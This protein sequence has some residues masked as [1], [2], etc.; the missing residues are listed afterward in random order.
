M[1]PVTLALLVAGFLLLY[2][3]VKNR[4][5]LDVVKNALA[6]KPI[7]EARALK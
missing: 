2:G 1:N 5:P 7:G 4:N 6:G 3:A